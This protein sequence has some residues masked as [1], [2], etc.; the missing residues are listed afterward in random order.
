MNL[1]N[2]SLDTH[3]LVW[4]FLKQET[5]SSKAEEIVRKVFTGKAQGIISTMVVLEAFYISYKNKK[6]VF[7]KFLKALK[8]SNIKILPFDKKVLTKSF[9]LP[10]EIDIHDRIIV[11]TAI[12]TNS[13]LVTKDKVLRSAFPVE[14]IW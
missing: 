8:D 14:T 12:T 7:P 2:Y 13:Q 3:A 6:F 10:K 5:L 4:Y 9:E 11:A 1:D